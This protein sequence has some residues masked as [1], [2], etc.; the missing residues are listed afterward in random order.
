[1]ETLKGIKDFKRVFKHAILNNRFQS[2][3]LQLFCEKDY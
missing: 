3:K 2:L 1:L